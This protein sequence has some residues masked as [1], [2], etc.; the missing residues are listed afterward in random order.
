ML[1]PGPEN[2]RVN[3]NV[4]AKSHPG[5]LGPGPEN[6]RVNKNV[7]AKSQQPLSENVKAKTQQQLS[8]NV[9]AKWQLDN[10]QSINLRL[11]DFPRMEEGEH[12]RPD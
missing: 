5:V 6:P 1:G 9:R 3:R 10:F 11:S 7:K 12:D 8:R 4:K 2:P